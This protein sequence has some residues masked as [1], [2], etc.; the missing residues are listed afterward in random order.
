[1]SIFR[2]MSIFRVM[3][4][5]WFLFSHEIHENTTFNNLSYT[6]TKNPR[7]QNVSMQIQTENIFSMLL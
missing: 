5:V 1:M 6:T 7:S 3:A 2:G 4:F